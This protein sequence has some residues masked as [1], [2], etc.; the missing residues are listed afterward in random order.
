MTSAIDA[1]ATLAWPVVIKHAGDDELSYVE[2]RAHWQAEPCLCHYHYMHAD[3]LID[4]HGRLYQLQFD[5]R[6]GS[7]LVIATGEVISIAE[8]SALTQM[9]LARLAQCCISK[10]VFSDFARA[11]QLIASTRHV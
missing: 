4:T 9:H 5:N 1:L 6:I 2:S 8:F 3:R 7:N 10:A 11:F